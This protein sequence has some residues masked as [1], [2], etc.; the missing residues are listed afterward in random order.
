MPPLEQETLLAMKQ[1]LDAAGADYAILAHDVTVISAE[2]G[3]E[4]GF[5]ALDDMAPTLILKTPFGYL[6]AIL[7]GGTRLS[8]KKIKKALGVKDVSLA[9]AEQ[10]MQVT[11]AEIGT[12]SLVNPG[13]STLIDQ[14]VLEREVVFGGCGVACHTLRIRVTDLVAVTGAQVFDFTELKTP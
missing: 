2:D 4:G 11:G 13:L 7:R 3:V 6:A 14:R 5:G 10:V 9:T 12:I 8:Y 1:T